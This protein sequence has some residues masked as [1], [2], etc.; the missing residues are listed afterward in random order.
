MPAPSAAPTRAGATR[1]QPAIAPTARPAPAPMP[2][3]VTARSPQVSPQADT[4]R[5]RGI[6][7]MEANLVCMVRTSGGKLVARNIL[8]HP[9][10]GVWRHFP[11]IVNQRQEDQLNI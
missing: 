7:K 9:M 10:E 8:G 6:R 5:A 11:R 1:G 4:E 2:P 3:P